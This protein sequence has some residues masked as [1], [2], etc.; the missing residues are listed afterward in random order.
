MKVQDLDASAQMKILQ[1]DEY[2]QF[3]TVYFQ[4]FLNSREFIKLLIKTMITVYDGQKHIRNEIIFEF[5]Y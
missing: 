4:K 5:H 2:I 3:E 1:L